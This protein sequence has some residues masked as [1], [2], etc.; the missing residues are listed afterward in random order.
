MGG[1]IGG[2]HAVTNARTNRHTTANER[3]AGWRAVQRVRSLISL[4]FLYK[5]K[6]LEAYLNF[7]GLQMFRISQYIDCFVIV[8]ENAL[9]SI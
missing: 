3:L 8:I 6:Y 2:G 9:D 4:G 5:N 1:I 7:F